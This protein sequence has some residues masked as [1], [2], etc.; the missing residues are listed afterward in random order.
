MSSTSDSHC[1]QSDQSPLPWGGVGGG[2]Y[3]IEEA[4]LRRNLRL[5]ADVARR[6][7]VEIILAFKAFALW[8]TFPI[9]REYIHATTASSLSEARLAVEQFG[10][11]AHTYS[12][13]YTDG[14]IDEIVSC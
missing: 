8:K 3:V 4:K 1:L 12:P 14:E 10:A 13:A 2:L 9:F 6:A 11:L 5:I 7:D